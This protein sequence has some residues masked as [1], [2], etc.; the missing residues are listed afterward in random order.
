MTHRIT[1]A[2]LVVLVAFLFCAPAWAMSV[3]RVCA[4]S[5]PSIPITALPLWSPMQSGRC[6]VHNL[7]WSQFTWLDHVIAVFCLAVYCFA[8]AVFLTAPWWLVRLFKGG[9]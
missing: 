5:K 2:I 3:T 9:R 1:L 6:V 4:C 8:S 7:D